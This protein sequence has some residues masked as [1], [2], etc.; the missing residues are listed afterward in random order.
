MDYAFAVIVYL[1]SFVGIIFSIGGLIAHKNDKVMIRVC[2][3]S[4]AF[5]CLTLYMGGAMV[6]AIN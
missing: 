4:A 3:L 1:L 5:F 6:N 2:S